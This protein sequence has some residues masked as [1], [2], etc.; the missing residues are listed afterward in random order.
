MHKALSG[1]NR[2]ERKSRIV[3]D[4]RIL[5]LQQM[6]TR[7]TC[8][9]L[10]RFPYLRLSFLLI[11]DFLSRAE[12]F[13]PRRFGVLEGTGCS[14]PPPSAFPSRSCFP[15]FSSLPCSCSSS[16]L[17]SSSWNRSDCK[18]N[19]A[20]AQEAAGGGGVESRRF[21]GNIWPRLRGVRLD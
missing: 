4:P 7:P 12:H 14:S 21:S 15:S 1:R 8:I 6:N 17:K 13:Q 19:S 10:A 11:P 16:Y 18:G 3:E 5:W 20:A 9:P 2:E